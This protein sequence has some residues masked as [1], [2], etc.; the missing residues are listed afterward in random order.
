MA[1]LVVVIAYVQKTFL[2]NFDAS[3][4]AQVSRILLSSYGA[5]ESICSIETL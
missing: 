5:P 2:Q 4:V 1:N 3:S